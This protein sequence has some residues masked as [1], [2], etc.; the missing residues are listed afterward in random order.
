MECKGQAA[1]PPVTSCRAEAYGAW[2][3]LLAAARLFEF[4]EED[5]SSIATTACGSKGLVSKAHEVAQQ[6]RSQ[7]PSG[8]AK[9]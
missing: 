4:Y 2:R 7:L 9:V 6:A 3:L 5:P 8:T 1:G